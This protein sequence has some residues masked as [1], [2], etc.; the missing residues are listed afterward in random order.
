MLGAAILG[1]AFVSLRSLSLP[2]SL[3]HSPALSGAGVLGLLAAL[4]WGGGDFSGGMAVKRAGGSLPAAV[5]VVLLS[6]TVSFTLLAITAL[7]RHDP[8]PHGA[9]VAW[10]LGAG[11][12][13]AV[14]VLAFYLALSAGEMGSAAAVSGLLAAAI[15]AVVSIA[16]EGTPGLLPL[17]GFV[18]AAAAIWLIAA[19]A[20][21]GTGSS[22]RAITLSIAAG[23]GFGIYFV[24]LRMA[25]RAGVL[26][27]MAGSRVGSLSVCLL[28]LLVLRL[29]PR[30]S[31]QPTSI[32]QTAD[33]PR[34]LARTLAR[35]VVTWALST[36]LLDT[37]GNLFFIASTRAG[38]LDV[39]AVLASLYPASTILLAAWLLRERPTLRQGL[40]M[41]V[42][43]AA[44]VLITL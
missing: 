8:L 32:A 38:R 16:L 35:T 34:T 26:W 3:L 28:L 17:L 20:A 29:R 7:L 39:A 9:P 33:A 19:G 18:L 25:G 44:V 2:L 15:P 21:P 1:E 22:R 11:L 30:P 41:L 36:A 42:A 13:G 27:P 6:H 23:A 5:R 12:A 40:G 37:A 43:A 14:S 4:T 10:S 31:L 24:A